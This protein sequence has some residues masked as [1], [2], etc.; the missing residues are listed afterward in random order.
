MNRKPYL[1]SE[2]SQTVTDGKLAIE[3]QC[4]QCPNCLNVDGRW[5]LKHHKKDATIIS[6]ANFA[7]SGSLMKCLCCEEKF[8][9]SSGNVNYGT[10]L[11]IYHEKQNN[12][13]VP[14]EYFEKVLGLGDDVYM[15]L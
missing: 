3:V 15:Y 1:L 4:P 10:I 13:L 14:I 11:T 2:F 8:K 5:T 9:W 7:T 12:V 6:V